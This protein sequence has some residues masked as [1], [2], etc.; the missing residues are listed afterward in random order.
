MGE[1]SAGP[2]GW[3]TRVRTLEPALVRGVVVA[4]VGVLG[5]WGLD[6]AEVG[7][8]VTETWAYLFPL[9]AVVQAW[10]TRGV[11][12]PVAKVEDVDA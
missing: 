5:L 9:I 10:W 12:V 11:V 2:V 6:V 3:W 4:I 1:H 7:N 8:K